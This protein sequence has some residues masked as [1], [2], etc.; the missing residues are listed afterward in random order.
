MM[1]ETTQDDPA[2]SS[3]SP[4]PRLGVALALLAMAQLIF[5]L[6]INIVFV[7]LP[8]IGARLDFS[9]QSLQWVVGAYAVF[10]GGFLLLGGRAADLLGRR[11]VFI[12]ALALYAIGSLAGGLAP[13]A[14]AIVAARAVQGIG[15]ALLLPSTLALI[16]SLF[17]EGPARNRALAVWGGAGASGLTLGALLGGILTQAFGWPAVFF[18]N[19]P[20]A[21]IVIVGALRFIPR[22]ELRHGAH[23]FDVFGAVAGTL[24]ALALVFAIVEGPISGWT[25]INVWG[26][27]LLAVGAAIAFTNIER[28]SADPLIAP[29]LVRNRS[30]L[31]AAA[32]TFVFMGTFGALPYFLTELFQQIRGLSALQTGL[33]FLIPSIAIASG[34]QAG[35]RVVNRI[36]AR[37]TV[38]LGFGVGIPGT[39]LLAIAFQSDSG[40]WM[41]V[42][43]LLI[44]GFGQG[45][46]WT[47]MW[48]AAATG[49]HH[50]QQGVANGLASTTLSLG[51]AIGL[52]ALTALAATGARDAASPSQGALIAVLAAAAAMLLGIAA[53]RGVPK[54]ALT[55]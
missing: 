35:E 47:S 43:G 50:T 33:I 51:N 20:L 26:A 5:S 10:S 12:A 42:P 32:I 40:I 37:R 28:R 21:A 34:T 25:S 44:S 54:K 23:L 45:I 16:G 15:G 13:N 2:R 11:R 53:S 4:A 18:V 30:L 14:P 52:A 24:A 19:V 1:T 22:D 6:D 46:V 49:V 17:A 36:G 8:E 48:V 38:L 39:A 7:A 31:S 41:A 27:M 3:G 29:D 9:P 55:D